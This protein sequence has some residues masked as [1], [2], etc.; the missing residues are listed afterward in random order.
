MKNNKITLSIPGIPGYY[1]LRI[2]LYST[3]ILDTM[4]WV[5]SCILSVSWILYIK[6]TPVFYIYPEYG[7]LNILLYSTCILDTMYWVYFCIL[8]VSWILILSI[9]LY[10]TCSCILDTIYWI[11]SCILP[12][13]WTLCIE[14][15][16]VF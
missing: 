15:T 11:Y 1:V 3:C 12:V 2:L 8:T 16:I 10:S 13:S 9:L 5:Y 14:Y 4:Y 7:V 6:Y